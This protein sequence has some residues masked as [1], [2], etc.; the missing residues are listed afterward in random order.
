VAGADR[1]AAPQAVR[2]ILRRAVAEGLVRADAELDATTYLTVGAFCATYTVGDS[3]DPGW[4][5][6]IVGTVWRGIANVA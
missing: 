6:E 1:P 4:A 5:E 2:Q 3:F